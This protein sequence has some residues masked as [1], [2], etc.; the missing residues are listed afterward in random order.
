VY[1]LGLVACLKF[2][3]NWGNP[4]Y[5][6]E[7][8]SIVTYTAVIKKYANM[9][10]GYIARLIYLT[11]L[12]NPANSHARLRAFLSPYCICSILCQTKVVL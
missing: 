12:P 8:F 6:T 11:N 9:E 5:E 7:Q 2:R 3:S 4:A 1:V 10:V